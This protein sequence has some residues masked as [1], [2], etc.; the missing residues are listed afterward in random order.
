MKGSASFARRNHPAA[1]RGL[2]GLACLCLLAL[3]AFDGTGAPAAGASEACE[4]EAVR[5]EQ[6]STY[7]PDCRAF[8]QASPIDKHGTDVMQY[9]ARTRA[10]ADG[11]SVQ[12][13]SLGGFADV[14]SM[15]IA[16]E[17]MS[18]RD[19]EAGA[20][21]WT[22]H[23][24][25]PGNLEGA[26]FLDN[27]QGLE[28]RYTEP[29]SPNLDKGVFLTTTPLTPGSPL[30]N[31]IPKLYLRDALHTP[32]AGHYQLLT[33]CPGCATNRQ[34]T[35]A[36]AATTGTYTLSFEGQT[37]AAI[38]FAAEAF[39][40]QTALEA[41]STIGAGNVS[42][43]GGPGNEDGSAP[44]VVT[45]E[46]A[47][48]GATV[49][50]LGSDTGGL[51]GGTATVATKPLVETPNSPPAVAGTSAD[52]SHI[53]FESELSLTSDVPLCSPTLFGE[54]CPKHLYEW[55][56]GQL[57]L[58]GILPAGEG[59]GPAPNSQAGR[60]AMGNQFGGSTPHYTPNTI[61]R[62]GSRIFFTVINE[63]PETGQL[64]MRI[65]NGE[66][67]AHT[68][69]ITASESSSPDPCQ[70]T[71]STCASAKYWEAT[72]DGS[73][74]FFTD[75]E[76][77]TDTPG[78][79]L[80]MYDA[81]KPDSAPDN[82]TLLYDSEGIGDGQGSGVIG[83]SE[84]GNYV[85]FI[86]P[87]PGGNEQKILAWHEGSVHQVAITHSD[88]P[89][90]LV[91]DKHF[92]ITPK[93]ARVSPDGRH[94]LFVSTGGTALPHTGAGDSCIVV[95]EIGCREV[96]LYD[97]TANDGSGELTCV[98]CQ[99]D[100]PAAPANSEATFFTLLGKGFAQ[101]DSY[102]NHPLSDNG[103]YAFFTTGEPLVPEDNDGA[104]DVYEYE[105]ATG[106]VRLISSGTDP[107]GSYF[108]DATPDG[109]DV[110]FATRQ[111]LVGWDSDSAY[112]LYDARIG[113]GMPEPVPVPAP[114]SGQVC[115]G[116]AP[117]PP[118]EAGD[119]SAT[120]EGPPSAK[121]KRHRHRKHHHHHKAHHHKRANNDRGGAR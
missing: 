98:S 38:P 69:R 106:E 84:D 34:Q 94:L 87:L 5:L 81:S 53:I 75:R 30:T 20:N 25:T 91:A 73:R 79:G 36:V 14:A 119:A 48:F 9:S 54:E 29:F 86:P 18:L 83:A 19:P 21:G 51:A 116:V 117:A 28:S 4:N 111:R 72:P 15:G 101:K 45:F 108:M 11:S 59:G 52:F 10:A 23:A 12:F 99:P 22:T 1:K 97:A 77:L 65:D 27:S 100:E 74:V 57:S 63:N 17:Y 113:G 70:S 76:Q 121:P 6:H 88:D 102:L 32:G 33:D 42:V 71:P 110:F 8:E 90:Y 103:R 47:L 104:A 107:G 44:Y 82:L 7:L 43:A 26:S 115:R 78:S 105:S 50:L 13:A 92:H 93:L 37:T 35:L 112:D 109:H 56:D 16:A 31:P 85:Y 39:E 66:P 62:D 67:D 120:F 80:Y 96:Y 58:A 95:S 3:V 114:C 46:G 68:V 118:P 40:V 89:A 61:S 60:G 41:L 2:F 55:A 24:I 64:Y 49:P